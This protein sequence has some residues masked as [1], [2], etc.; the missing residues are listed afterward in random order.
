MSQTFTSISALTEATTL[1]D[2][3]LLGIY[4]KS[5]STFGAQKITGANFRAAILTGYNGA[6][7]ITVVGTIISGN[8]QG[9][10]IAPQYLG[11]G[12]DI[13]AKFL[14]GDGTWQAVPAYDPTNVAITGGV[15]NGVVIGGDNPLAGTFTDLAGTTLGISTNGFIFHAACIDLLIG[16]GFGGSSAHLSSDG[17]N[18]LALRNTT[19]PQ[20]LIVS[21]TYTDSGNKE[22]GVFDW[23][24]NSNVLTIGAR[25]SGTGTL[26]AVNLIGSFIQFNGTPIAILTVDVGWAA[27]QSAGD[28]TVSVQDFSGLDTTGSDSCSQTALQ[29]MVT[30]IRALTNKL[31]AIESALAAN[32]IPNN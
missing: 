28:K 25:A 10:V 27:N 9:G 19:N 2:V 11:T 15:I 21:N 29:T 26:R 17:A 24:A 14:Q 1:A 8:W 16:S 4:V 31:Q 32:Q 22:E 13:T 7:S 12:T 6:T 20:T 5:G 23:I 30:Q 18:I 3:D